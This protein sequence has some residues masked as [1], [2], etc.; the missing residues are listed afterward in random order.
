M[1]LVD[2][3]RR[4]RVLNDAQSVIEPMH[5]A[6]VGRP[7]IFDS[8]SDSPG[9]GLFTIRPTSDGQWRGDEWYSEV[10]G[11]ISSARVIAPTQS[12]A[13][14]WVWWVSTRRFREGFVVPSHEQVDRKHT[15]ILREVEPFMVNPP[16][17][18]AEESW[19][20]DSTDEL[21]LGESGMALSRVATASAMK[22]ARNTCTPP[23]VLARLA[24]NP[25]A[26]VRGQ[27]AGNP[28]T[29]QKTIER[30]R[31]HDDFV[32]RWYLATRVDTAT[33]D[34]IHW[35]IDDPA[36]W[37]VVV[38]RPDVPAKALERLYG[39]SSGA[40]RFGIAR[41]HAV[42]SELLSL[43]AR[44]G[45]AD[46]A[47]AL[48]RAGRCSRSDIEVI[49]ERA[50]G[51]PV[52]TV[53]RLFWGPALHLE[54]D[55]AHRL[56][57][58]DLPQQRM[59]A[60]ASNSSLTDGDL[61]ALCADSSESV[62]LVLA[63]VEGLPDPISQL[64]AK[65]SSDMVRRK[66]ASRK[67]IGPD[68]LDVLSRDESLSVRWEVVRNPRVTTSALNRLRND[69]YPDTARA[70]TSAITLRQRVLARAAESSGPRL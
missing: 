70:A 22:I 69:P 65:D 28:A 42:S 40:L 64:L 52:T 56:A 46:L 41:H 38:D 16:R 12:A 4:C 62:R 33:S 15:A 53:A 1:K 11:P 44:E 50:A 32:V 57:T 23:P 9:K 49:T 13:L 67:D 10:G 29:P 48:L 58:S 59:I 31:R 27:V 43:F 26:I 45:D 30:L 14:D 47:G 35:S 36:L 54:A 24:A 61:S 5:R 7:E 18:H 37:T 55:I 20:D 68:I 34:I 63:T 39:D 19:E 25:S 3:D 2:F 51:W 6:F 66:L 60:A 17:F 21:R 8:P